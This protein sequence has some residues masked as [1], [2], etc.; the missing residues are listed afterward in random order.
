MNKISKPFSSSKK[1]PKSD[2]I[3]ENKANISFEIIDKEDIKKEN[4]KKIITDN[5]KN[6]ENVAEKVTEE[7]YEN[8]IAES[9]EKYTKVIKEKV[10]KIIFKEKIIKLPKNDKNNNAKKDIKNVKKNVNINN[11]KYPKK[12]VKKA[13]INEDIKKKTNI[14]KKEK[15]EAKGNKN[16]LEEVKDYLKT[17]SFIP[18]L[19]SYNEGKIS[20]N[21][22]CLNKLNIEKISINTED[23]LETLNIEENEVFE[24]V[25]N[26]NFSQ[27]LTYFYNDLNFKRQLEK[28]D[29]NK[30]N[31]KYI[32]YKY[33]LY[34]FNVNDGDLSFRNNIIHEFKDISNLKDDFQKIRGIEDICK[35]TGYYIPLKIYIGGMYILDNSNIEEVNDKG[36]TKEFG[37]N[38]DNDEINAQSEYKSDRKDKNI[39]YSKNEKITIIGG[40]LSKKGNVEE[41]QKSINLSNARIIDYENLISFKEIIGNLKNKL[42]RPLQMIEDKYERRKKYFEKINSLRN[43]KF[44]MIGNNDFS[45]GIC[46]ECHKNNEPEINVDENNFRQEKSFFNW[47]TGYFEKEYNP[48]DNI[49]IVGLEIKDNRKDGYNGQ[50]EIMENPILSRKVKI[51]FV[52]QYFRAEKFIIKIYLMKTPE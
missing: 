24:K 46:Q 27:E 7:N 16:K 30:K 45:Q 42:Y 33:R 8:D 49:I 35:K 48:V 17:N 29:I 15:N 12:E 26:S 18:C 52:S 31:S 50:W 40:D 3:D 13:N 1:S 19:I 47:T 4:D 28:K 43:I 10:A 11:L 20:T 51:K 41:W 21:L 2:K 36:I 5:A 39:N 44:D 9:N 32:I 6:E 23:H 14:N 22:N 34:S 25:R 37:Q 38:I